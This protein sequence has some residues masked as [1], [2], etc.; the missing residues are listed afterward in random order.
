MAA[1]GKTKTRPTTTRGR[2]PQKERPQTKGRASTT[3]RPTSKEGTGTAHRTVAVPLVTPHVTVHRVNVP[4]PT[5]PVSGDEMMTA[6][7][8]VTSFL[9]PPGRLAYYAGLG[10]LA[11]FGVVEWPV[12][13]AIGVGVAVAKRAGRSSERQHEQTGRRRQ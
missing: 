10:A 9:A 5:L 3:K 2:A 7:K 6:G 11:A 4:T 8:A 1:T 13:A 12:A